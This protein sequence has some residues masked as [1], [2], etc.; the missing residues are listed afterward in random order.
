MQTTT[1][2]VSQD[3][4]PDNDPVLRVAS[5]AEHPTESTTQVDHSTLLG[6]FWNIKEDSVSTNKNTKINL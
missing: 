3:G 2:K 5:S 1:A 4:F 6:Y